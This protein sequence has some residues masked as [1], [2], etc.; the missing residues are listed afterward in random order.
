MYF[1]INACCFALMGPC[2]CQWAAVIWILYNTIESDP[3]LV[4]LWI[5]L[6]LLIWSMANDYTLNVWHCGASLMSLAYSIVF[7]SLCR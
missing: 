1:L 3:A 4:T 5:A 2:F 7:T 6:W